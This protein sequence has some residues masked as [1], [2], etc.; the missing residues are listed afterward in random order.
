MG[1]PQRDPSALI[2]LE[3]M[4]EGELRL[5]HPIGQ[6]PIVVGSWLHS[7]E[8]N[9]TMR[10]TNDDDNYVVTESIVG[11]S[12]DGKSRRRFAAG[13]CIPKADAYE[14]GLIGD[15]PRFGARPDGETDATGADEPIVY[16]ERSEGA[17][18]ENRMDPAPENRKGSRGKAAKAVDEPEA[19][20][21]EST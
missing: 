8:D 20:E 6:E 4:Q 2:K 16:S 9:L 12:R 14:F 18:P 7:T 15:Q 10:Y 19:V 11:T 17:A 3:P 13:S 1:D 21:G 5:I